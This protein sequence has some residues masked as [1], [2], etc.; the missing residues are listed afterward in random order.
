LVYSLS[1]DNIKELQLFMI[2]NNPKIVNLYN[3]QDSKDIWYENLYKLAKDFQ[4]G[5]AI[6]NPKYKEATCR[7][8]DLKYMCR[9]Y[10]IR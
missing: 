3:W 7:T 4:N 5:V 9:V 10:A 1:L 2:T 6:V 8:C